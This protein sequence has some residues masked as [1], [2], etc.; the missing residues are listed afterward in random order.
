MSSSW[1]SSGALVWPPLPIWPGPTGAVTVG[2]R[3]ATAMWAACSVAARYGIYATGARVLS[4]CNNT[5][6]HLAPLALVA[7]VCAVSRRPAGPAALA[8]EMDVALHLGRSGAPIALPSTELPTTLHRDGDHALTFWRY[9]HHDPQ[10]AVDG[11]AAGRALRECHRALDTYRAPRPSFL[12]TQVARAGRLLADPRALRELPGSDRAFLDDQLHR[13]TAELRGRRVTPRLLHGDPHRGNLLV[14]PRRCLMIDFESVCMGPV[15]WDL[16]ALPGGG[17]GLFPEADRG[18]L[19]LLRQLRSLCVAV[20]CSVHAARTAEL[21]RAAALH[22]GLLR[23]A[24]SDT[25]RAALG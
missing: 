8:A 6:V 21:R 12:D 23:S 1:S 24:R 14:G 3:Q 7:K 10:L 15:E 4:D 5:V 17:A 2:P 22:L 9:E 18:L 16:S 19:A 13:L 20:W 11:E 25:E